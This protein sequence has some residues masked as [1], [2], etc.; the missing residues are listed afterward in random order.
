MVTYAAVAH[1]VV[2]D[3]ANPN[4]GSDRLTGIES[5]MGTPY[6]DT[7]VSDGQ[8]N[9]FTGNGG[10]DTV[11]YG[12][13]GRGVF[14]VLADHDSWD[15][16]ALDNFIGIENATGSSFNDPLWGDAAANILDGGPG[17]DWIVGNGG[18][19]TLR[20]GDGNDT[21]DG[22][23]NSADFIDGGPGTDTVTYAGAGRAV[24]VDLAPWAFGIDR[25]EDTPISEGYPGSPSDPAP[26][27]H[28]LAGCPWRPSSPVLPNLI[29]GTH[30][31]NLT[32]AIIMHRGLIAL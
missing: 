15:G 26:R 14:V 10:S 11:N 8:A 12:A 13:S 5:A 29:F 7:F 17:D 16:F 21:I 25:G 30:T 22:G 27:R 19:D 32:Y 31:Y 3:L 9:S 2:V 20:G 4:G 18:N 28:H 6:D 23:Y 24:L 1:G